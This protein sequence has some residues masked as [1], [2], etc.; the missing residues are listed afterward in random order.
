MKNNL[1]RKILL[2]LIFFTISLS[3]SL[4]GNGQFSLTAAKK[5]DLKAILIAPYN[6]GV[7]GPRRWFDEPVVRFEKDFVV[8]YNGE[9]L[10]LCGNSKG[11][12]ITWV[13][14]ILKMT[15]THSDGTTSEFTIDYLRIFGIGV[16]WRLPPKDISRFFKPG[17]NHVNVKLL[18][19]GYDYGWGEIWLVKKKEIAI[20]EMGFQ[21]V[22]VVWQ[23][24]PDYPDSM[25]GS[26]R[27][28]NATLPMVAGKSTLLFGY[29][30]P[31]RIVIRVRNYYTSPR[32]V[33]IRITAHGLDR[34]VEIYRTEWV[35]PPAF[36][37]NL[38]NPYDQYTPNETNIT[39]RAPIPDDPFRLEPTQIIGLRPGLYRFELEILDAEIPPWEEDD[40][41]NNVGIV[42]SEFVRTHPLRIL[43]K[44]LVFPESSHVVHLLGEGFLNNTAFQT[45]Q[46]LVDE[47]RAF[48]SGTYPVAERDFV[49]VGPRNDR[50][51]LTTSYAFTGMT[52]EGVL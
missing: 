1:P 4:I 37:G 41:N 42:I 51:Y 28:W 13:D 27:Y 40:P 11:T 33:S 36:P 34:K 2:L 21:P 12:F 3:F 20:V 26:G 7:R 6:P 39:I 47:A 29:P 15:I 30:N 48:I 25:R 50:D 23:N 52:P 22:Q 49:V 10:I 38:N 45:V 32:N 8:E 17:K 9:A 31:E 19:W 44:P 43:I 14:D 16:P 24:D 46:E 35:L 18:D 5:V